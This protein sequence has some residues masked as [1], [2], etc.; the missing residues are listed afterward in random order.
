MSVANGQEAKMTAFSNLAYW[1]KK[2]GNI[3]TEK[4]VRRLQLHED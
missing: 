4:E 3:N 1:K 2:N